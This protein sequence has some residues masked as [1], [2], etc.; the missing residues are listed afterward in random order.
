[1]KPF[2]PREMLKALM[3]SALV[4]I[5]AVFASQAF[6]DV[7]DDT[8]VYL[9]SGCSGVVIAPDKVLTAA[10]C[11][12]EDVV[13]DQRMNNLRVELATTIPGVDAAVLVVPGIQCP[14][15]TTTQPDT[16]PGTRTRTGG[17]PGGKW[18]DVTFEVKET[19][20][21][22]TWFADESG[23]YVVTLG[24]L[25]GGASGSGAWQQ[26]GDQ[27]MLVGVYVASGMEGSAFVPLYEF[28]NLLP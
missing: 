26:V 6:A 28:K 21:A 17:F 5:G 2:S 14:C 8:T 3:F 7:V 13:Q 23:D 22:A 19:V 20:P 24:A 1:M 27:W 18:A 15:A 25:R 16:T 12:D 4:I 11:A 10:H 9:M